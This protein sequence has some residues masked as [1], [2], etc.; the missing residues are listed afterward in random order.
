LKYDPDN[1]EVLSLL[2]KAKAKYLE[3]EGRE[4]TSEHNIP[5]F[6]KS[7]LSE[8][9][10]PGSTDEVLKTGL[11]STISSQQNISNSSSSSQFTRVAIQMESDSDSEEEADGDVTNR[12]T[13]AEA[14]KDGKFTRVAIT[15]DSDSENEE[16]DNNATKP[17]NSTADAQSSDAQSS[18]K[19]TR[20]VIEEGSSDED[21]TEDKDASKTQQMIALKEQG[22][23]EMKK[24][25]FDKAVK[26]YSDA[27]NIDRGS[28]ESTACYCN[29]SLAYLQVKV[30]TTVYTFFH[31]LFSKN[32]L[33][34]SI[35]L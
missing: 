29:R 8:L 14:P 25:Q 26:L 28:V 10:L 5:I 19:L 18:G 17:S 3:V 34:V 21:E 7:R 24:G 11:L 20:I 33:C 6:R 4:Y 23:D 32:I 9:Y 12:G 31:T 27:I 30:I 22:N 13:E 2:E 15:E 16:N 35:E 1:K